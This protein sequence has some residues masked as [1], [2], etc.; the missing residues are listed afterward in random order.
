MTV[1]YANT[2]SHQSCSFRDGRQIPEN[3]YKNRCKQVNIVCLSLSKTS[4]L[5]SYV[6]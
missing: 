6:D 1:L 2:Y 4:Q 5:T 3:T